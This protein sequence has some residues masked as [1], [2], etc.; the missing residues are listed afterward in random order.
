MAYSLVSWVFGF[1][2]RGYHILDCL[3]GFGDQ[4]GCWKLS[5]L[6]NPLVA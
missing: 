2:G 6:I 4:V 1:E 5:V 3:I